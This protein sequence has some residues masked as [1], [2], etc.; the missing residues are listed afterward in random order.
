MNYDELFL[1]ITENDP[2]IIS[3]ILFKYLKN[4][5]II[6]NELYVIDVTGVSKKYR[7]V[8]TQLF[9]LIN[10]IRYKSFINIGVSRQ[11]DI[12]CDQSKQYNRFMKRSHFKTYKD[13][14]I[15]LLINNMNYQFDTQVADIIIK[16]HRNGYFDNTQPKI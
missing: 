16:V 4:C 6:D 11:T 3:T 12:W 8:S 10:K 2:I 9:I 14:L 7:N 15:D 5:Y 1:I 13:I